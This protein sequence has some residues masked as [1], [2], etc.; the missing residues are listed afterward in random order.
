MISIRACIGSETG[1]ACTSTLP[2]RIR[3]YRFPIKKA[4]AA[5]VGVGDQIADHQR[6]LMDSQRQLW[7]HLWQIPDELGD[8]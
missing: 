3:R 6:N 7:S 4:L 2:A 8:Q 5:G 1:S